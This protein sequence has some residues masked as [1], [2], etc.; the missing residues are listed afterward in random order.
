MRK[1]E[2][3][4]EHSERGEGEEIPSTYFLEHAGQQGRFTMSECRNVRI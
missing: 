4:E 2:N 3:E 1:I